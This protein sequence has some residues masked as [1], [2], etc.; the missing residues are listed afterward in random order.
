MEVFQF[1]LLNERNEL[2]ER[3]AKLE[4]DLLTNNFRQ[5]VGQRQ[6]NLMIKQCRYMKGYLSTLEERIKD[7]GIDDSNN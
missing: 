4:K 3:L 7:L 1:R 5:K 2:K 6:Y